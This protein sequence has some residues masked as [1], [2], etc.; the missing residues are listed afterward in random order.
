MVEPLREQR[1]RQ[2]L[3]RM[4][5]G[6]AWVENDYV[7]T[8][9]R[10]QPMNQ[11]ALAGAFKAFA[12]GWGCVSSVCTTCA[13]VPPACWLTPA[14]AILGH[15][16]FDTTMSVYTHAALQAQRETLDRV[17]SLLRADE[18]DV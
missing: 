3:Q 8:G 15:S 6:T 17:G 12:R 11:D 9:N 18:T 2:N 1:E 5:A 16:H 14:Q 13:T 10:G 7:F 4:R